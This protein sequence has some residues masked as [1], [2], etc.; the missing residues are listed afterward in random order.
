ML[1]H[2]VYLLSG[3][4]GRF[5]RKGVSINF[6]HDKQSWTYMNEIENALSCKMTRVQTDEA[7]AMEKTIKDGA[8]VVSWM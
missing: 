3:R 8:W 5:G 4:T 7:E 2:F 1:T 6:V